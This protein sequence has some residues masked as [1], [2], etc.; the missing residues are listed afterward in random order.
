[1]KKFKITLLR[2]NITFYYDNS[3][4]LLAAIEQQGITPEYGCRTGFCGHCRT[5]AA[6]GKWHYADVPLAFVRN[7]QILLCCATVDSDLELDM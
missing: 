6:K 4:T 2:S 7:D 5:V 3:I 1:M